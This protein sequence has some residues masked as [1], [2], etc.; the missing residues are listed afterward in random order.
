MRCEPQQIADWHRDAQEALRE[1][2]LR[3][4]HQHCLAILEADPT[5]ADAWFLCGLI[6][7]H[8]RQFAKAADILLKAIELAPANAEYRAEL[9]RQYIALRQ[10]RRALDCAAQALSLR[11]GDVPTLNTLGVVFSHA[12]EHAR[13]LDCFEAATGMLQQPGR[14]GRFSSGWRAELYFNFA[15]ALKFAGRFD[16]AESA[17]E[18][19]IALQPQLYRAHSALAQLRRQTTGKNHLARLQALRDKVSSATDQLHLGHAIAKELEDLGEFT[20]ALENLQWAKQRQVQRVAYR[21]ATDAALFDRVRALFGRELFRSAVP[22]GG[23]DNPEPIFVVGMPRTGTTLVEQILGSHSS[24]FAAGELLAFP[25]QVKEMTGS[26]SEEVLDIATMEQ[27]LRLDMAALGAAYIDSTRPRTGHSPHF[28][29]KLPLN[30]MYLGLIRLALPGAKLIC[31]RRDPM[32]TCLS[33]YRQ[34]FATGF[35]H[36]YY[37][38]DLLDCG[39]YYLRFDQLIRHWQEVLPGG[40]LELDYEELVTDPE[41]AAKKLVAYCGLPWEQQ[42]LDFHHRGASVATASAVQVRQPIYQNAIGRWRRYGDAMQPLYELLS[43]AGC[44]PPDK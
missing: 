32:D 4:A 29:D 43:A 35:R 22:A 6:A 19:A 38:Y 25:L 28:I 5:H 1:G 12:G 26:E 18:T 23:C 39:R 42:C 44:Y 2:R 31:L 7:A 41:A 34:L 20:A 37:S 33:N 24:V 15:A 9:S 17:C 10:Y 30:F 27:S 14:S 8:N 11:P 40:L 16:A 36:Y 21:P 13:A 3:E